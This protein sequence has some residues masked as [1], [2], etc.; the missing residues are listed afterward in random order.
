MYPTKKKVRCQAFLH[1]IPH[2]CFFDY[3][4]SFA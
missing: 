4:S 3:A 2:E 1:F